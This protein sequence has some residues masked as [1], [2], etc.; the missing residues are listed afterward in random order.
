ELMQ[1]PYQPGIVQEI[2]VVDTE[3]GRVGIL[4]C[5]DTF[6]DE[7]R[8]R[9]AELKPDWL[10]IPFGWAA[11]KEQWPAHGFHLIQTIQRTAYETGAAALGP[12]LVGQIEHGPWKGQ[13]FEGLS[14]ATDQ[15]G[16][17]LAQA[18]WNREELTVVTL[19]LPGG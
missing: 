9:M 10:Y 5:A 3:F 13:T 7:I 11:P 8:S 15:R 18:A 14:V 6:R 16:H 2:G 12:N 17:L 19:S 4:I 1:P